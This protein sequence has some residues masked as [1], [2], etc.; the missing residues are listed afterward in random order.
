MLEGLPDY[1]TFPALKRIIFKHVRTLR[2][3][4]RTGPCSAHLLL[5]K[6]DGPQLQ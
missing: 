1:K 5:E 2:K 6:E 3:L 4:K